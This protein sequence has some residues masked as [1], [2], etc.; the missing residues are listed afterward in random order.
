MLSLQEK[1]DGDNGVVCPR[2]KSA[3]HMHKSFKIWR[4]PPILVVQLK[5][6]QFDRTSRRKLNDPVD[7]PLDLLDLS[8]Y[9]ADTRRITY[10]ATDGRDGA[11][12][13]EKSNEDSSSGGGDSGKGVK[14]KESVK[15]EDVRDD[16]KQQQLD[17]L[18]FADC[19]ISDCTQ[20]DLYSVIH[21][22]GVMVSHH[23][24]YYTLL[25]S[26]SYHYAPSLPPS[27]NSSNKRR[28]LYNY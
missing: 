25:P 13:D 1:L 6:F 26:L 11:I 3:D 24:S 2:C 16:S 4:Q 21:H 19:R 7:F 27:L 8:E 22:V 28:V 17:S 23:M 9:I 10:S 12:V 15:V 18:S 14:D 20:Y 5:R